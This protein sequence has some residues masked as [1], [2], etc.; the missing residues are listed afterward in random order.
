MKDTQTVDQFHNQL[1][2]VVN[3]MRTHGEQI[4]DQKV[5]EKVSRSL[6][7]KF[8]VVV[9]SIEESKYLTQLSIDELMGS[10]CP[11]SLV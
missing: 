4:F 7:S 2:I 3:Q 6:P 9:V 11:M 1:M 10:C 8:D 5:V